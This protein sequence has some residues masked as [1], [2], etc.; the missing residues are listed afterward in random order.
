MSDELRL[1]DELAACEA[2]LAALPLTA[3]GIDRDQLLYRAGWA[4]GAETA[5]LAVTNPSPLKGGARGGITVA[6]SLTSA[7][8][9]AS[10]AVMLTLQWRPNDPP[11]VVAVPAD[12]HPHLAAELAEP[13]PSQLPRVES[14]HASLRSLSQG[15]ISAGLLAQRQ[16]AMT[17][18]WAEPTNVASTAGDAAAPTAQTARELLQELLPAGSVRKSTDWPWKRTSRGDSI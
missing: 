8:V 6:W 4:A 18:V 7:A 3:S 16:R 2:K 17:S 9:A 12:A 14:A 1:P 5:R 15:R 10:I 11:A 13:R